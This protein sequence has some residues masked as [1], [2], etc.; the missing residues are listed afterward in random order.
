MFNHLEMAASTSNSSILSAKKP[1]DSTISPSRSTLLLQE[2]HDNNNSPKSS[3]SNHGQGHVC[4]NCNKKY[5]HKVTLSRH[6]RL[7]CRKEPSYQC[8][9]CLHKFKRNYCL[10]DHL[11]HV[12]RQPF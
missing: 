5:M 9:L 12:H 11:R 4:P 3:D 6:I 10:K 8:P 1:I 2:N 7:E